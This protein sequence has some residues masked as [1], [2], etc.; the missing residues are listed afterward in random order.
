MS[1]VSEVSGVSGVSEVP[2]V[3]EV[4]RIGETYLPIKKFELL[5][6]ALCVECA[7]CNVALLNGERK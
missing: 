1:E 2:E 3:P 7:A 6:V 4:S 5:S